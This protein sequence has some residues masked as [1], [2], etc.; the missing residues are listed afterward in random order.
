MVNYPDTIELSKQLV[1]EASRFALF[2][3]RQTETVRLRQNSSDCDKG[4]LRAPGVRKV[5]QM[6]FARLFG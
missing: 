2:R 1:G 3:T 4:E 6:P 5:Q